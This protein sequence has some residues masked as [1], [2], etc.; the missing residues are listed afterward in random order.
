MKAWISLYKCK[1]ESVWERERERLPKVNGV[2]RRSTMLWI[3][4][5]TI[6]EDDR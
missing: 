6:E 4:T 5:R 1:F 3:Q 2:W